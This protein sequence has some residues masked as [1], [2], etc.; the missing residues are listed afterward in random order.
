MLLS[1]ARW[2]RE[3]TVA[4]GGKWG[5]SLFLGTAGEQSG[6]LVSSPVS[7][8][9]AEGKGGGGTLCRRR[10]FLEVGVSTGEGVIQSSQIRTLLPSEPSLLSPSESGGR[11]Q[12][13]R[14]PGDDEVRSIT[15]IG[16]GRTT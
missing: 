13:V 12:L 4:R 9:C 16:G 8:R 10:R 15:G 11:I 7:Y 1:P 3:D 2:D 6:C 14:R 5:S